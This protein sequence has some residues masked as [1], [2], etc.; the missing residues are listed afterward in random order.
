V[1]QCNSLKSANAPA[2]KLNLQVMCELS[3]PTM[4]YKKI[5]KM[6]ASDAWQIL[7]P[8]LRISFVHYQTLR[9]LEWKLVL[10]I[11]TPSSIESENN[12][13]H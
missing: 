6:K 13:Q 8:E 9:S 4:D 1:V 11:K 12:A 5:M 7:D 3:E 10:E 2:A